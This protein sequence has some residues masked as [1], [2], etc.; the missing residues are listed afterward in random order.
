LYYDDEM[1]PFKLSNK[2]NSEKEPQEKSSPQSNKVIQRQIKELLGREFRVV[3]NG[4]DPAEVMAF[5]EA[6]A[7]SSEVG[8]RR[9]ENFASLRGLSSTLEGMIE[10]TRQVSERIKEQAKQEAEAEKTQ[11]IEEAKRETE[12]L[13]E[14][15]KKSCTA[16][17]EATNSVL[18]EAKRKTE[19]MVEQTKKSC[20]ALIEA[21]DSVLVE[22]A[23]KARQMEEMAFQKVKEMVNMNSEAVQQNAHDIVNSIHSDLSS[24]FEQY[25]KELSSSQFKAVETSSDAREQERA[26]VKEEVPETT[27]AEERGETLDS[28]LEPNVMEVGIEKEE[29]PVSVEVAPKEASS[30]LYSGKVT[31]LIPREAKR[32]WIQQLRERL[33][34]NPGI[35][36]LLEAGTNTNMN[37]MILSLD[38]PVPLTSILREMPNV[39]RV[40]EEDRELREPSGGLAKKSK[41]G[42]EGLQQT[43]LAIVFGEDTTE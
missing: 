20:I 13:A 29:A 15:T 11:V 17:V 31:L 1:N 41:Q 30:G 39:E 32:S 5:L 12:E 33:A 34:S 24:V 7:G 35:H 4:L 14:Q 42:P 10:E 37:I 21:T 9:L 3:Q 6:V 8:L 25:N 16:L 22:A 43:R 36:I 23:T 18:S 27:E 2:T 19:E 38:K 26:P 28:I 40:V